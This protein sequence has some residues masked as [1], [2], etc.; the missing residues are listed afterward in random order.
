MT[1]YA[2]AKTGEYPSD[3][4]QLLKDI[5]HNRLHLARKYARIFVLVHCLF[6]EA[7]S[8]ASRDRPLF[9]FARPE[10]S[11][12]KRPQNKNGRAPDGGASL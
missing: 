2:P 7:H 8:F 6:L 4:P 5:K 1:E 3:I 9:P 12:E 11:E 10:R